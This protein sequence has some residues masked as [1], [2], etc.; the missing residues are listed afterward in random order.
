MVVTIYVKIKVNFL[1][2][3]PVIFSKSLQ[4]YNNNALK[5]LYS[6]TWHLSNISMSNL[7]SQTLVCWSTDLMFIRS[8]IYRMFPQ[9]HY[10]KI[11]DMKN[12]QWWMLTENYATLQTHH[13]DCTL[14]WR[15]NGHFHVVST[16]N[17]WGVF[18]GN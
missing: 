7:A 11:R 15:G 3:C 4:N 6:V 16:R 12:C 13:A 9:I 8:Y 1:P 18:V 10:T 17:P 14:K 2:N 5:N